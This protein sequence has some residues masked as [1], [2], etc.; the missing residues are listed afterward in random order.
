VSEPVLGGAYGGIVTHNHAAHAHAGH[1]HG[2]SAEAD[3]GRL[4]SAL[5]LILAF[6]AVEITVGIIARSL[7]LL[8]DAAHMLTDAG[9]IG[10]SLLALRLAHDRPGAR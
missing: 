10:F 2:I 6:M 9:A 1:A 5:A 8:S 4:A 3:K 7:A